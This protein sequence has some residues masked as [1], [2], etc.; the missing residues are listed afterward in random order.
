MI[1]VKVNEIEAE[2]ARYVIE[3][4]GKMGIAPNAAKVKGDTLYLPDDMLSQSMFQGELGSVIEEEQRNARDAGD[5]EY[6]KAAA[7]L[8][9]LM[10]R[11]E[12]ALDSDLHS[13]N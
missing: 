13:R 9:A 8:T 11:I 7:N 1:E 5:P 3:N 12:Q 2:V 10:N 6:E 4:V